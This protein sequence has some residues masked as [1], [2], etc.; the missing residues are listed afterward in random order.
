[1]L[2][3]ESQVS[4][5]NVLPIPQGLDASVVITNMGY[6]MA[7]V[8][9]TGMIGPYSVVNVTGNFDVQILSFQSSNFI[10]NT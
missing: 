1:M 8:V 6:S 7:D 9:Y 5:A 10:A 3:H 2:I 4:A